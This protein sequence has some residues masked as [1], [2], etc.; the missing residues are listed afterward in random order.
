M[1]ISIKHLIT[2]IEEEADKR[3]YNYDVG[4]DFDNR[5][6]VVVISRKKY[7]FY[8]VKEELPFDSDKYTDKDFIIWRIAEMM[9]EIREKGRA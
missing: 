9:Q 7:P 8:V 1:I 4:A 5:T 2:T 3:Y 6:I